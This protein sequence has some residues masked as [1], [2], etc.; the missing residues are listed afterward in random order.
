L[1]FP[2]NGIGRFDRSRFRVDP[3]LYLHAAILA[4]DKYPLAS[5]GNT[6]TPPVGDEEPVRRAY[7]T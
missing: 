7:R 6:F 4:A 1:V 3:H 2:P 5:I